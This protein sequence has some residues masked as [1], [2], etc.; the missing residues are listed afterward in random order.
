MSVFVHSLLDEV[1]SCDNAK[2]PFFYTSNTAF[3]DDMTGINGIKKYIDLNY[4]K[5]INLDEL[6]KI[7]CMNKNALC[8]EFRRT[9]KDS[10]IHYILSKRV[11][12]AKIYLAESSI[13]ITELSERL[14]FSSASY[15]NRIFKSFEGISP[16]E[17]R[18]KYCSIS[19]KR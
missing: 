10:P 19:I 9:Y 7:S 5:Q 11:D 12:E 17:Y 4:T 2:E 1:N 3:Y 18:D 14:G 6:I 15:F 16:T 8:R 13:K